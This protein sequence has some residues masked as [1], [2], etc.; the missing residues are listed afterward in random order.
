MICLVTESGFL[1]LVVDEGVVH[2]LAFGVRPFV[3]RRA[4]LA[5]FGH[6]TPD[7]RQGFPIFF[8]LGFDGVGVDLL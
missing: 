5:I 1:L 7:G 6:D 3:R 2:L 8:R 4:R